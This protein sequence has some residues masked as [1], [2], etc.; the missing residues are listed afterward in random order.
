VFVDVFPWLV[1]VFPRLA[2]VL[3]WLAEVLPWLAGALLWLADVFPCPAVLL[4]CDGADGC[5]DDW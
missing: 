5:G 1:E 3:L 4:E 2:G